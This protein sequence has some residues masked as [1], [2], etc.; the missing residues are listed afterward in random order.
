M[1]IYPIVTTHLSKEVATIDYISTS[2]KKYLNFSHVLVFT[3]LVYHLTESQ[4]SQGYNIPWLCSVVSDFLQHF[5]VSSLSMGFYG[6]D[7]WNGL[8]FCPPGGLLTRRTNLHLCVSCAAE[9]SFACWFIREAQLISNLCT[10]RTL[11]AFAQ[12]NPISDFVN[13][14]RNKYMNKQSRCNILK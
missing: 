14:L 8:P 9:R 3:T 4:Q 12:T 10:S 13:M 11:I 2:R 1:I 5:E 7:N 6:Q